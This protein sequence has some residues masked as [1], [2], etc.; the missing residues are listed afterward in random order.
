MATETFPEFLAWCRKFL[1]RGRDR[2]N[3]YPKYTIERLRD[4]WG[5]HSADDTYIYCGCS[6]P[7]VLSRENTRD[8][9]Y[10]CDTCNA[11]ENCCSCVFCENCSGECS[12][13]YCSDCNQCTGSR[14]ACCSCIRCGRC[15]EVVEGVCEHCDRCNNC[16]DGHD[17]DEEEQRRER[18]V[19]FFRS[20]LTF[21][22]SKRHQ[23]KINPSARYLSVEIEAADINEGNRVESVVRKWK[24]S[25]VVDGSLPSTGF[26]INTAPAGGD[27]FVNQVTEICRALNDSSAKVTADCGLHVH[28]DARDFD[29][30]MVRRLV[31]VY[32]AIEPALFAMASKSRRSSNYCIPCGEKYKSAMADG[33]AGYKLAK[34]KIIKTVYAF[35][36]ETKKE[37]V[38]D[39]R[40]LARL[41]KEKYFSGRYN[42]LNLHSWF[43]RGTIEC[44]LFNGTVNADKITCWGMLW[45][46]IL[47]YVAKHT[48]KEVTADMA[49]TP[50]EVLCKIAN[51]PR[52]VA[53]IKERT[54]KFAARSTVAA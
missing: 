50:H 41:K 35:D 21:H 38:Y 19:K 18:N 7:I 31:N 5:N 33:A 22:E 39:S 51:S 11:C 37:N 25:V 48:D 36:T 30:Y 13:N 42:A 53:F 6:R 45:A 44:R 34:S 28:I 24:G 29:Y 1:Q 26:E 10:G 27:L 43:H 14:H 12:D 16:C 8:G 9:H 15:E 40:A 20:E 46:A 52:L 54:E 47:D 4:I 49:G 17:E 2:P 3:G 32:A 23:R